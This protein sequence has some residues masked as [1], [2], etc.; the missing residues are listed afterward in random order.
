MSV[1]VL[2]YAKL[3]NLCVDRWITEGSRF[4]MNVGG[5]TEEIPMHDGVEDS[6]P[7]NNEV[8][9]RLKNR[10][11]TIGGRAVICDLRN[12]MSEKIWDSGLRI[13]SENDL[14]GLPSILYKK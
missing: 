7:T 9:N 1:I 8:V 2:V 14:V 3:H 5:G 6:R 10:Y 12:V 11:A 13:K 4:S